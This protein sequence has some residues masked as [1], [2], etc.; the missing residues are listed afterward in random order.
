MHQKKSKKI[1]IYFFLFLIFGT[2][3]NKKLNDIDFIG[4]NNISVEGLGDVNNQK[5]IKSLI[6]LKDTNLFLLNKDKI[7]EIIDSNSLVEKY[8]VF[9]KYPSTIDIK[10]DETNFLAMFKKDGNNFLLGSNGKFTLVNNDGYNVPFIFGNFKI[11]NFFDLEKAISD[12]NFKYNEIKNLF[13]FKSGRWDIETKNG[14]L[15]KLPK[16]NIQNSLDLAVNFLKQKDQKKIKDIDLRQ[17][18]QIIL[19]AG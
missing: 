1:L 4:L 8:T 9:K 3:N 17:Q 16:D 19:N 11:K 10:I 15:I 18:N 5:L 6:F 12:S 7:I 2:I 13:F 14:L